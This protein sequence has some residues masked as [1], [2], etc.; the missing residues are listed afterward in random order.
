MQLFRNERIDGW[1]LSLLTESHLTD[2]LH[3][4]LGPALKLRSV[5]DTKIKQSTSRN[6]DFCNTC[7]NEDNLLHKNN[8]S[9]I[10]PT[11]LS[12]ESGPNSHNTGDS[13]GCKNVINLNGCDNYSGKCD[14]FAHD[15][16]GESNKTSL[17]FVNKDSTNID[18]NQE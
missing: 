3:L 9:D 15:N 1:S 10:V 18:N 8:L 5:L 14:A 16:L 13:N 11:V 12:C 4:K 7:V 6:S 2:S 17:N